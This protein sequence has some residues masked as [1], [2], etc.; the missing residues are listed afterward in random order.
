MDDLIEEIGID[1]EERLYVKPY[2]ESFPF[3]YREGMEVHWNEEFGYL[4]GAKPRKWSYLEWFNQIISAAS[5]QGCM[6]LVSPSVIWVNVPAALQQ[7]ITGT[8]N[9]KNT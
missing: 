9:A 2:N 8:Q 6:L 7:K 3:I 4:Y 1:K 5:Q